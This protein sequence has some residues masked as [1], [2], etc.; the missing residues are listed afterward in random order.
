MKT[1]L[2]FVL[3]LTVSI[4]AFA[5]T[6]KIKRQFSASVYVP[7][8][9]CFKDTTASAL[10]E[11]EDGKLKALYLFPLGLDKNIT[12]KHAQLIR[13]DLASDY[14]NLMEDLVF[15]RNKF[16]DWSKTAIEEKV[17][18]YSKAIEYPKPFPKFQGTFQFSKAE[19]LND[20]FDF[21]P[22]FNVDKGLPYISMF[23]NR[24]PVY[25]P[26]DVQ[27][28]DLISGM[29]YGLA[30]KG[31]EKA[32]MSAFYLCFSKTEQVDSFINAM[33]IEQCNKDAAQTKERNS[34]FD[35]IFR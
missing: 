4:T 25:K 21:T 9:S 3:L 1:K 23:V 7:K 13:K 17:E 16:S 31:T 27:K 18:K 19:W 28:H 14:K 12:Y 15:L 6:Y 22:T 32:D 10:I 26:Y 20:S 24:L 35:V 33:D 30:N 34:T 2:L 5:Q 29:V 11:V 8:D